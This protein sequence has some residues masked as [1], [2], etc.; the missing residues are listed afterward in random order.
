M[1][2]FINFRQVKNPENMICQ[3]SGKKKIP[4]RTFFFKAVNFDLSFRR[5]SGPDII[6]DL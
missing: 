4:A 6:L 5:I 3:T 1:K 2:I